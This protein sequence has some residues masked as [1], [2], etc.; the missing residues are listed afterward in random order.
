MA[1]EAF[2]QALRLLTT[3]LPGPLDKQCLAQLQMHV[4]LVREWNPVVGL[5]SNTDTAFI[6]ERHLMDSLSLVPYVHRW[7]GEE[8][9]LLDI[10]AGGGFPVI[11]VKCV[12][13]ELSVTIVERSVRKV[14]FL[15]RVIAILGLKGVNLIHGNFPEA[16]P[17]V[18]AACI[19][20]RAVERP[21]QTIPAILKRMPRKC[22]F[23]CQSDV[24]PLLSERMFHVEQVN[25]AWRQAALRRGELHIITYQRT[26]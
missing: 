21:R 1:G 10:G 12:L 7:C 11:P 15:Q 16:L 8:G 2:Q 18:E 20:A 9:A 4:N 13:P 3:V 24:L 17:K 14:G 26:G 6:E 5:V 22:A 23:L 25:D 19:T